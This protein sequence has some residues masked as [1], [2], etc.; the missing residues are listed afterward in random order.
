MVIWINAIKKIFKASFPIIIIPV[1]SVTYI[2]QH[3][4][5]TIDSLLA[6]IFFSQL[7]IIWAQLEVALRQNI[8]INIRI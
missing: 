6:I 4:G 8:F 5:V 2:I 3:F 7:Y 1:L